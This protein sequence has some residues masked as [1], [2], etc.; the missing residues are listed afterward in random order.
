VVQRSRLCDR[1]QKCIRRRRHRIGERGARWHVKRKRGQRGVSSRAI[2]GRSTAG[3]VNPERNPAIFEHSHSANPKPTS[4]IAGLAR[5]ATLLAKVVQ[6]LSAVGQVD[7]PY[8]R[9]C[10]NGPYKHV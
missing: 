6:V 9:W 4:V 1:S 2:G 10:H 5:V 3:N 7:H 8:G